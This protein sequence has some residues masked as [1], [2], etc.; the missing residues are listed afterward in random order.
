MIINSTIQTG[1]ISFMP[2]GCSMNFV[3]FYK[4]NYAV[5]CNDKKQST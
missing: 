4:V 2:P 1:F 3:I 5:M